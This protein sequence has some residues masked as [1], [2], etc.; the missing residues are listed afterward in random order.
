L[1]DNE[2]ST[3][4]YWAG[5]IATLLSV[6]VIVLN[7]AVD[8]SEPGWLTGIG[9]TFLALAV[10]F[11][12]PPFFHLKRFGKPDKGDA[13]FSTTRV[14]DIGVYSVVRHPQYIGYSLLLLGFACLDPHWSLIVFAAGALFFFYLQAIFEERYCSMHLGS[15]YDDYKN[16]TPRFNFVLGLFRLAKARSR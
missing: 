1:S 11:A 13:Y 7:V 9:L 10:M 12:L 8:V 5:V 3:G 6:A 15:D 4:P 16:R 14:V 2:Q